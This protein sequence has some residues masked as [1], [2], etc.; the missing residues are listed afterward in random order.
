MTSSDLIKLRIKIIL[1]IRSEEVLLSFSVFFDFSKTHNKME[2][3][4]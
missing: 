1:F 3:D 4:L 2:I